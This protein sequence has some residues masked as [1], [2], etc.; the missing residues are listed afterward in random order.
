MMIYISF[1]EFTSLYSNVSSL[2]K[3]EENNTSI[4]ETNFISEDKFTTN[5]ANFNNEFDSEHLVGTMVVFF[6]TILLIV[7][8]AVCCWYRYV[9]NAREN[10]DDTENANSGQ[11]WDGSARRDTLV[12]N[13]RRQSRRDTLILPFTLH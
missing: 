3:M 12:L 11:V 4:Q 8:G 9:R 1:S 7:G 6:G 10:N 13:L 2:L 5:F